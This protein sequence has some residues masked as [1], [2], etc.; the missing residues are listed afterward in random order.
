[1]ED[2]QLSFNCTF[3]FPLK[4][5]RLK[6]LFLILQAVFEMNFENQSGLIIDMHHEIIGAFRNISQNHFQKLRHHFKLQILQRKYEF[7]LPSELFYH[8]KLHM[9]PEKIM[10]HKSC[11]ELS[12]CNFL[13]QTFIAILIQ[14]KVCAI[15]S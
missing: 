14:P 7:W 5:D 13:F 9:L 15:S 3:L 2:S 1:M 10:Q 4:R 8:L 11:Y 12:A 6:K